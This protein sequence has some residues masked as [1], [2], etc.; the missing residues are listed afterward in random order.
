MSLLPAHYPLLNL[1]IGTDGKARDMHP[2]TETPV[3]DAIMAGRSNEAK[4]FD[5]NLKLRAALLECLE[6]FED[7]Y[8]TVDDD[9]CQPMPNKEMRL[10]QMIQEVLDRPA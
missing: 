2:A 8:D 10:G 3:Y 9:D 6:Y 7:R 4:L 1:T 5:A